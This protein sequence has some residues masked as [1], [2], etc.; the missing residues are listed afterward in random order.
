MAYDLVR[1]SRRS[2][3]GCSGEEG[4]STMGFISGFWEIEGVCNGVGGGGSGR[5]RLGVGTRLKGET[6]TGNGLGGV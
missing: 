3:W 4:D 5:S 2:G 1:G 6:V